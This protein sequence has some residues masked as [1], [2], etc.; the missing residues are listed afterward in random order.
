AHTRTG[1]E[2]RGARRS[3]GGARRALVRRRDELA[4]APE[5]VRQGE[6]AREPDPSA[7]RLP[8]L[9]DLALRRFPRPSA[10]VLGGHVRAD[11]PRARGRRNR[12]LVGVEAAE[13]GAA[14]LSR[15]RRAR[16]RRRPAASPPLGRLEY[17]PAGP[18]RP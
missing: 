8:A 11:R 2:D 7:E 15:D 6:R 3:R 16:L 5:R 4:L 18:A 14:R 10:P 13:L 17:A 9:R 12:P 1:R